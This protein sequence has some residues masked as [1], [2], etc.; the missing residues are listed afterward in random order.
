MICPNCGAKVK[1]SN[2]LG[3]RPLNKTSQIIYDTLRRHVSVTAAAKELGCSR[4]YIYKILGREKIRE[5]VE[6]KKP[7]LT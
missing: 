5:V 7:S 3:R 4:P 2:G 1:V 6:K